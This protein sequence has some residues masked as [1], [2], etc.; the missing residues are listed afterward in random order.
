MVLSVK[1]ETTD[2]KVDV[3]DGVVDKDDESSTIRSTRLVLKAS[4]HDGTWSQKLSR[5]YQ[6]KGNARHF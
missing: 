3:G 1:Q 2:G 4:V 5:I 6:I